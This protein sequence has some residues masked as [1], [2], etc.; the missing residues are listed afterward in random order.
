MKNRIAATLAIIMLA[1]T[2]TAC[3]QSE[4]ATPKATLTS[5]VTENTTA[6]V[7]VEHTTVKETKKKTKPTTVRKK[8]KVKAK[9][10]K[11]VKPEPTEPMTTATEK[12]KCVTQV[13]KPKA[14]QPAT[15]KPT[16]KPTTKKKKPSK[17]KTTQKPKATEKPKPSQKA[18]KPAPKKKAVDKSKAVRAGI[19]YGKSLGMKYDSSLSVGNASWLPPLDCSIYDSTE[20]LSGACR[21]NVKDLVD[22]YGSKYKPSDISFNVISQGGQIYVVYG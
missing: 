21:A 2:M 19:S 8:V 9:K 14:T 15:Q 22:Y 12:P 6:P 10:K 3:T 13:S 7:K 4:A 18:T 16:Q 1:G 20:E 5:K 11:V 17:P